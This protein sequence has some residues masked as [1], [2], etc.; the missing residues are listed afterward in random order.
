M[1]VI[2]RS[3][4]EASPFLAFPFPKL[5]RFAH[6]PCRGSILFTGKRKEKNINDMRWLEVGPV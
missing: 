3:Q 5:L 4:R 1:P 2:V 6:V